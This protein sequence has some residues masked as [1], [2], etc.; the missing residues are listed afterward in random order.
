MR[1]LLIVNKSIICKYY[2]YMLGKSLQQTNA[3]S[4]KYPNRKMLML[5]SDLRFTWGY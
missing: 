5:Y 2:I 4:W 3:S 1:S